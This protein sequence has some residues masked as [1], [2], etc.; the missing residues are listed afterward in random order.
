MR[1]LTILAPALLAL[2]GLVHA[3][4]PVVRTSEIIAEQQAIRADMEARKGRYADMPSIKREKIAAYQ[5]KMFS[6]LEGTADTSELSPSRRAEV[7][8]VQEAIFAAI[9]NKEDERIVCERVKRTGSHRVTRVCKSV[10]Q[11]RA[12]REAARANME[13][14]QRICMAAACL[15]D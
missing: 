4:D 11:M 13:N 15:E 6:L 14:Q 12:D 2:S 8:N 5:D 7:F 1:G 3:N 10:A 9:N